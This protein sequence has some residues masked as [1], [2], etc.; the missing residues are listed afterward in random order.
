MNKAIENQLLFLYL[1]I[2]F[3][4]IDLYNIGP[5]NDDVNIDNG[6]AKTC[7]FWITKWFLMMKLPNTIL[8][9]RKVVDL[10][11]Y[12]EISQIKDHN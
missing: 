2:Y 9:L 5:N 8:L 7:F 10:F 6:N 4:I 3:K 1:K 11:C 12:V